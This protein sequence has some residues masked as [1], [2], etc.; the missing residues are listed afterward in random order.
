VLIIS[1]QNVHFLH[2]R[3]N[4]IIVSDMFRTSEC[5]PA[6]TLVHVGLCFFFHA[7]R[8]TIKLH[9]QVFLR[10]NKW[11][12]DTYQRRDVHESVYRDTI[13]KVSNKM[14]LYRLVYFSLSALHVSGRCF[15]PSSGALDRIYSIW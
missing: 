10:M 4:L 9:V 5:S 14:Q 1:Q 7:E 2:Y 12:F 6:G 15:R 8:N 3:F 13:M 11:I